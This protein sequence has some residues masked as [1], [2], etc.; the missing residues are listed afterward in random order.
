MRCLLPNTALTVCALLSV[1]VALVPPLALAAQPDRDDD[2]QRPQQPAVAAS[3]HL[4]IVP[5]DRDDDDEARQPV[6][7]IVV[8]AQRLD[9]ARAKIEPNLGASTYTLSNEAV[10]NRPSGETT[11]LSKILLQAPGVV[12]DG[13]GQL[14]VRSQAN[15]QYRIN[16]VIVPEGLTDIGESLSARLA[17]RVQ[18]ITGALPAQYG[19]QVGGIVNITTKS[20][21]YQEGGQAELYGGSHGEIQPAFEYA[22][23]AEGTNFFVTGS[24]LGSDVGLSAPDGSATPAHDHTDQFEGFAYLDHILDDQARISLILGT[25]NERF[26]IP[27]AGSLVNTAEGTIQRPLVVDDVSGL[28]ENLGDSQRGSTNY[29]MISYLRTTDPFTLQ[30]S[31]FA[32]YS[33]LGLHPNDVGDLSLTGLG[34]TVANS[35]LA[36]GLQVEGVYD[37]DAQ[38]TVRAGFVMS[39]DHQ[40]S[41]TRSLVLPLNAQG[42]QLSNI[43]EAIANT[44]SETQREVSVFVQDEWRPLDSVTVNA[45]LRFEHANTTSSDS[46]VSPRVNLVWTPLEDTTVHA[47]YARYFVPPPGNED[48]GATPVLTGTTGAPPSLRADPLRAERD[49][50]YDIGVEQKLGALTLGLDGYWRNAVNLIDDVPIGASM[51]RRAFNYATGRVRGVELSAT[52]AEGPFSA[53]SNLAVAEAE[54]RH[55]VSNQF[56]FTPADLAFANQHFVHLSQDQSYTASAGA[57]Y[58]W[59]SAQFSTDLLYGSGMRRT[60]PGGAPNGANLPGYVQVNLAAVYHTK[61]LGLQPLDLRLDVINLLDRRY[62]LRDGSSLGGGVPQWGPRRGFFVGFEQSF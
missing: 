18:L 51:L 23:S 10:E 24:Y 7:E 37:V 36:G 39:S 58:K 31:G 44:S 2:D 35:D 12:Q 46:Q 62:E 50:Y 61:G 8:T 9:V 59:R 45:G 56:S 19:L 52:Y 34:Q 1:L 6:T 29:G 3:A 42:Q 28:G 49:D 15:L 21:V 30:V 13:S 57:S 33:T 32:R 22:G 17:E 11:N 38:H 48:I 20:G 16:N 27:S 60:L 25:S 41:D 43:P 53:W 14:H 47:G 55:I 5:P 4:V 26:Q 54:G 40:K